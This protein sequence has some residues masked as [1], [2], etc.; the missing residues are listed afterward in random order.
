MTVFLINAIALGFSAACW[1]RNGLHNAAFIF[2][3]IA[4]AV[5][6]AALAAPALTEWL[7]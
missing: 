1:N 4:L 7:Q 5:V 3:L 6:N 2:A